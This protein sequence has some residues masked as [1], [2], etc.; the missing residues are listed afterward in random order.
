MIV[1][2]LFILFCVRCCQVRPLSPVRGQGQGQVALE[3]QRK[4][5]RKFS[6]SL[7]PFPWQITDTQDLSRRWLPCCEIYGSNVAS[8]KCPRKWSIS[9]RCI[10]WVHTLYLCTS[11]P[12][13]LCVD[14]PWIWCIWILHGYSIQN[15]N[16][17][18][19]E[20]M[21]ILWE[22]APVRLFWVPLSQELLVRICTYLIP[23]PPYATE[24]LLPAAVHCFHCFP[25]S[26]PSHYRQNRARRDW[27]AKQKSGRDNGYYSH[28]SRWE[29]VK[30]F[31][32]QSSDVIRIPSRAAFAWNFKILLCVFSASTV[33]SLC[34]TFPH[35]SNRITRNKR[36]G[37]LVLCVV[38]REVKKINER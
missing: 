23:V 2:E 19:T 25:L 36:N 29:K 17:E 18:N 7:R 6:F 12:L 8:I 3:V 11:V 1:D 32:R 35:P 38:C 28:W 13:Y 26:L 22:I 20:N 14:I 4:S 33:F 10:C 15:G 21:S 5:R 9:L 27:K 31:A 24:F 30:R 37:L 16:R 34:V